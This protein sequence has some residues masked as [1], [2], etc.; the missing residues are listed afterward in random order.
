MDV[1]DPRDGTRLGRINIPDASPNGKAEETHVVNLVFEGTTLWCFAYGGVYRVPG[2][3][4][5]GDP[6]LA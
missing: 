5:Q 3:L 6:R 4:V 1:Y 2:L